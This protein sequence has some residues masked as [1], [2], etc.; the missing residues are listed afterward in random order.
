MTANQLRA[1]RK[2]LGLKQ[3]QLAKKMGIGEHVICMKETGKSNITPRDE[4][5]IELL[6]AEH[7]RK[8]VEPAG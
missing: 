2:V 7:R 3:K 1:A 5:T 6:M 8:A 4:A